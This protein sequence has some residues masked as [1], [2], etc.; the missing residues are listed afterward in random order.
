MVTGL[1]VGNTLANGLHNTGTLVSEND[2]ES[3]LR[4]LAGQGIGICAWTLANA[5]LATYFLF[6]L[7]A[8]L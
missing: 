3:T 6:L 5:V 7:L 8:I 2:G 4:V 1:H